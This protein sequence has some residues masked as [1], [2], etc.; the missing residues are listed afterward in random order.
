MSFDQ[1]SLLA[2][3]GF[4]SAALCATLFM[5]WLGARQDRFLLSWSLGMGL[6]V[7]GVGLFSAGAPGY[8]SWLQC[9]SLL[10]LIAGFALVYAGAMQLRLGF[11]NWRWVAVPAVLAL[12]ITA[13][14]FAFGLSGLGTIAANAG[15]SALLALAAAEYWR[16]RTEAPWP[17]TLNVLLYSATAVSFFLCAAALLQSGEMALTARPDNWAEDINAI[18]AIISLTGVGAVSLALNQSRAARRQRSLAMTDPLTGLLNRRALF[19]SFRHTRPGTAVIL[20][21]L[22]RFKAVNDHHGHAVGDLVLDRF[23]GIVRADI[24]A[25][26]HAARIGGEEFCIVLQD[27]SAAMAKQVAERIRTRFAL[28][29]ISTPAGPLHVTAS[30]GIA[31]SASGEAFEPLLMRADKA[32]YAAKDFG[33]NRIQTADLRL[34]A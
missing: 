6:I 26:D 21:D 28:E 32:L 12:G 27:A 8:D 15:I 17:M 19:D 24:R 5:T 13:T 14:S 11:A 7:G 9:G 2:A 16:G 29:P 33:R 23:A 30:G 20:F 34:V 4:S 1:F 10:L 22:D 31:V 18:M 3:V 25:Q